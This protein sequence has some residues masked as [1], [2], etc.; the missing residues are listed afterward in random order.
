MGFTF[1]NRTDVALCQYPSPQDAAAARCSAELEP[2]AETDWGRDC[3]GIDSR[4]ITMIITVKDGGRQ[5]YSRTASCGEWHDTGGRF[6]IEQ[7]GEEF[8]VT[9]SLPDASSGS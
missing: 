9:D 7:E 3:D 1:D 4:P 5:I 2:R 6:V 8:M